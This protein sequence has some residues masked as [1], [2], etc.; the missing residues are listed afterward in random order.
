MND[1]LRDAQSYIDGKRVARMIMDFHSEMR[2]VYPADV[3]AS[4]LCA[5]GPL[6]SMIGLAIK[7]GWLTPLPR[8]TE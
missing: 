1:K 5:V 7:N 6:Q 2:G 3:M 4:D 8:S